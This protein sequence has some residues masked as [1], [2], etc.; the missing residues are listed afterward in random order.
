MLKLTSVL[1]LGFTAGFVGCG[2]SED[3]HDHGDDFDRAY[4]EEANLTDDCSGIRVPDRGPF[5]KKIALTFDDG[6]NAATTP[7]ILDLLKTRGIKA[8][9]LINGIRVKG[10][11]EK[12]ILRRIVDEGHILGNHTQ[13]HL[14]SATIPLEQFKTQ[15]SKTSAIISSI[16][17]TPKY[18]RFPFGSS[19]CATASTV[20]G[21]GQIVTGWHVDSAD[22]CF[23]SG[24]GTCKAST[25]AH[26][27]DAWRNDMIG[28]TLSQ[29]EK[30]QGGIVLFHDIHGNTANSLPTVLDRMQSAGYTFTNID[31]T[32]VFPKL[33]GGV[34]TEPAPVASGRFIGS[35]CTQDSEC[36]FDPNALCYNSKVCSLPCE[37]SCPDKAGYAGTFCSTVEAASIGL[38]F[39][40]A[41]GGCPAGTTSTSVDR[42]VGDSG[43]PAKNSA[44]CLP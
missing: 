39:S 23:A 10:E 16:G 42:F 36:N 11:T 15:V 6:P 37:G 12:A 31:D 41:S 19:N 7:K 32:T 9:F 17:A 20:R 8:T 2:E 5:G 30:T 26:I 44:V 35:A 34:G 28:Y 40:S 33:N 3:E 4:E 18:F 22:W 14:N 43:K 38:C 29:L 13:E 25:F 24:A 1:L 27:P 21:T